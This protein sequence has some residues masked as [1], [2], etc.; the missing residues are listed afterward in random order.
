MSIDDLYKMAIPDLLSNS[1]ECS[2]ALIALNNTSRVSR[3]CPNY[4]VIE[5]DEPCKA[6]HTLVK[7]VAPQNVNAYILAFQSNPENET[8]KTHMTEMVER[9]RAAETYMDYYA[10]WQLYHMAQSANRMRE[11]REKIERVIIEQAAIDLRNRLSHDMETHVETVLLGRVNRLPEA[12]VDI[13]KSYLP[14]DVYLRVSMP[15]VADMELTLAKSTVAHLNGLE[16]RLCKRIRSTRNIFKMAYDDKV[17]PEEYY[18]SPYK[19]DRTLKPK[20]ITAQGIVNH[21][22]GYEYYYN[23]FMKTAE[24]ADNT[25]RRIKYTGFANQ[26]REEMMYIV[27][28]INFLPKLKKSRKTNPRK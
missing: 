1:R 18:K 20:A 23:I 9:F 19:A 3:A 2:Y 13:I 4:R 14:A 10:K 27:K 26:L 8:E 16:E 5:N 25:F 21:V 28:F 22:G 12:L 7:S 24:T 15:S 6:V 17:I 11:Q